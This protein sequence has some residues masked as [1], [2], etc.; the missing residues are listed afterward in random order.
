IDYLGSISRILRDLSGAPTLVYELVQNADD[1]PGADEIRFDVTDRELVVWNNGSFTDCGR[2]DLEPDE[3]P[4]FVADEGSRRCDFHSFCNVSSCDKSRDSN[5]T[6]A[7]GIVFTAG[8]QV[9]DRRDVIS[10]GRNCTI[11]DTLP[12]GQRISDCTTLSC[13]N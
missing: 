5:L 10:T 13:S 3:C 11:D 6:G 12:E 2:Q 4:W 7:F 1:A 8:Y 9:R